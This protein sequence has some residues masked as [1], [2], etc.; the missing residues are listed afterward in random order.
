MNHSGRLICQ[1]EKIGKDTA[2]SKIIQMVEDASTGKAPAQKLADKVA[3]IFVPVIL[4]IALLTIAGWLIRNGI[5]GSPEENVSWV[6]FAL[7]RGISVLVIACPCALGLATP[8]AIMVGNG[9]AA[10]HG[11]LF[12]TAEALEQKGASARG[13]RDGR[14]G[15]GLQRDPRC[16]HTRAPPHLHQLPDQ[17]GTYPSSSPEVL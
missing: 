7:A 5:A 4:G 14:L 12:K 10:K 2:L 16:W 9:V 8:V 11:I 17:A 3:G 13:G 1:A 6:G 15:E